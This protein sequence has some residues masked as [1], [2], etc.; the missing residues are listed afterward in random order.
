MISKN[1]IALAHD[2]RQLAARLQKAL[3]KHVSQMGLSVAEVNV[4]RVLL[5][6]EEALPSELCAELNLSSQF[7]SQVLNRLEEIDVIVRKP[8]LTDKRKV[9]VSL[10]KNGQQKVDQ[11]RQQKEEWLARI[12]S[13]E[14]NAQQ[15]EIISQ[16][17]A[18]LASMPGL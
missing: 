5:Q 16:A 2:L 14:Y 17:V 12:I 18:L 13:E 10:S 7:V 15:K 1:D 4:V 6:K 9:L 8:S 3:R 11:L